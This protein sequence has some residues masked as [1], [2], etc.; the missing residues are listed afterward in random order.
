MIVINP[1]TIYRCTAILLQ[2]VLVNIIV[3][4]VYF[5]PRLRI[6]CPECISVF[7]IGV[8]DVRYMTI[9]LTIQPKPSEWVDTVDTASI[10]EPEGRGFESRIVIF[11]FFSR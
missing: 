5:Y 4:A 2:S 1:S 11:Y 8:V 6:R 9:R 10:A 3:I 7:I